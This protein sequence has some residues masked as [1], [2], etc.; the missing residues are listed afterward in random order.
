MKERGKEGRKEG[1]KHSPE[2]VPR[3]S[4]YLFPSSATSKNLKNFQ[5]L[6]IIIITVINM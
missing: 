4:L 3:V 1:R 5:G 6:E 2:Y